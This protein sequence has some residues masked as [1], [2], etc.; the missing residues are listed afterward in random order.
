MTVNRDGIEALLSWL[1]VKDSRHPKEKVESD[2]RKNIYYGS[3][4]SKS[5][6]AHI[7]KLVNNQGIQKRRKEKYIFMVL[8]DQKSCLSKSLS[9]ASQVRNFWSKPWPGVRPMEA[10]H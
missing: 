4:R 3:V 10:N 2:D 8:L 7:V 9:C 5:H 1:I 6:I